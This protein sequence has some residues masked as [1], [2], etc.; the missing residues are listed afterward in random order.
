MKGGVNMPASTPS[1]D[2]PCEFVGLD[3]EAFD[4]NEAFDF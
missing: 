2:E 3:L 1:C 4:I